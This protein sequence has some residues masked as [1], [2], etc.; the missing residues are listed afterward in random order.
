M[1]RPPEPT[2]P[3]SAQRTGTAHMTDGANAAGEGETDPRKT[4]SRSSPLPPGHAT[5]YAQQLRQQ[6]FDPAP[7]A[8]PARPGRPMVQRDGP[9][10]RRAEPLRG[11]HRPR[12]LRHPQLHG[13][14]FDEG[15]GQPVE[16]SCLK[17]DLRTI[18]DDSIEGAPDS[19]RRWTSPGR[20]TMML[21]YPQL[22]NRRRVTDRAWALSSCRR[23]DRRRE[24]SLRPR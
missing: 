23:I 14:L 2:S 11:E 18:G 13:V 24:Q 8:H 12:H 19:P 1:T 16:T 3:S 15:Q 10:P 5:F 4:P 22:A 6:A 20:A 7:V 17:R 21:A 9:R